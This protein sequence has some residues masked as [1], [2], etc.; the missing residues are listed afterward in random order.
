MEEQINWWVQG[1]TIRTI[2]AQRGGTIMTIGTQSV[3]C[4]LP[5]LHNHMRACNFTT[6]IVQQHGI[7]SVY[8]IGCFVLWY[9]SY[10]LSPSTK[11]KTAQEVYYLHK[12]VCDNVRMGRC[13]LEYIAFPFGPFAD[14][15]MHIYCTKHD[16][17][18]LWLC[19]GVNVCPCPFHNS[20]AKC[21]I[22]PS[23]FQ[24]KV[25]GIKMQPINWPRLYE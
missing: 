4:F 3:G 6:N 10:F 21:L 7:M 23:L 8:V 20:K 25:L 15:Q 1:G 9:V 14:S 24:T 19:R 5:L 2:R 17:Q 12:S 18:Q 13:I 11:P 22:C 16:M